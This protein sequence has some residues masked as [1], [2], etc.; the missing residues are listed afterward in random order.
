MTGSPTVLPDASRRSPYVPTC[1]CNCG[2]PP[3]AR[4]WSSWSGSPSAGPM[5]SL[6]S[7]PATAGGAARAC[8]SIRLS[9]N[10]RCSAYVIAPRSNSPSAVSTSTAA[11]SRARREAIGLGPRL[12]QRVADAAHRMDQRGAVDVELL[13]EVAHV[14]LEHARVAAEVVLPDVLEQLSA[15]ED[16]AGVEHEVAQEAVLGCRE[17]DVVA[18]ARDLVRV[19]V[20]LDVLERQAARLGLGEA[21]AAQDR[22][23][24]RDELLEAERFRDVV[25]AAEGQAAD[26]VV[27]RVAGG[28]EDDRH[29]RALR[30]EALGDVEALHVRQHDVEHDEVRAE[31]GDLRERVGAG[32]GGLDAEALEPQGHRDDV[33]DVGL[34]VDD[35]DAVGLG[36]LAHCPRSIGAVPGDLLRASRAAR[37][38]T[39]ARTGR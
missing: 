36:G 22:A 30:A 1:S 34:V 27:G 21:R 18:G 25:V 23:D 13:A 20:E 3:G 19:L 37:V 28:E 15:R 38:A 9:R 10:E 17:L 29:P 6:A 8:W 12:A 26:L 35:E 7:A 2:P 33:D 11:S 24:A 4:S 32:A 16:A 39:R 31:R 5:P 14:G